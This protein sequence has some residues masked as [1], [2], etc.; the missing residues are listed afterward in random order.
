[1]LFT[2]A[3]GDSNVPQTIGGPPSRRIANH[4]AQAPLEEILKHAP[5]TAAKDSI[6][7]LWAT[8][9]LLPEALRVMEAWG[10]SYVTG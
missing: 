8:A 7:F 1:M 4:Y 9:P 5:A 6:L 3:T 10:Y 2:E